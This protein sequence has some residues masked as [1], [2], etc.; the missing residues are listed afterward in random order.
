MYTT[1]SI[2]ENEM[3]E[4]LE[5]FVIQTDPIIP[6]RRPDLELINMIKNLTV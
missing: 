5:N 4:I 6:A 1:E 2:L 3:H